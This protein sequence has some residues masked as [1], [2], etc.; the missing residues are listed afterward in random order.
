MQQ[1]INNIVTCKDITVLRVKNRFDTGNRDYLI[2][3]VFKECKLICE[4]QV[5]LK[6]SL[7][8]KSS[9]QQKFNH[10]LYTLCRSRFGPLSEAALIMDY[11]VEVGQYFKNM[12][13]RLPRNS[14]LSEFKPI[15]ENNM[16]YIDGYDIMPSDFTFLCN[17]CLKIS[18]DRLFSTWKE[19][20][21]DSYLCGKCVYSKLNSEEKAIFALGP[22]IGKFYHG[23]GIEDENKEKSEYIAVV[24][25]DSLCKIEYYSTREPN[26]PMD[27]V[28]SFLT[29]VLKDPYYVCFG[30]LNKFFA[31]KSYQ[32]KKFFR[33]KKELLILTLR[34]E[35]PQPKKGPWK[36][37]IKDLGV[38]E[39][40][41][42]KVK[43]PYIDDIE[44][45]E[46]SFY[47]TFSSSLVNKP[48]IFETVRC[49]VDLESRTGLILDF[50]RD[51]LRFQ[52]ARDRY[53]NNSNV[54]SNKRWMFD[55]NYENQNFDD[56]LLEGLREDNVVEIMKVSGNNFT[57]IN[58]FRSR[59]LERLFINHNK[60]ESLAA[61]GNYPALLE[62]SL[63][64]NG[65]EV[66]DFTVLALPKLEIL[67]LSNNRIHTL[68]WKQP[69]KK[70]GCPELKTL[71]L[72][73]FSI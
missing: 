57:R 6:E 48:Q 38:D 26:K 37:M 43:Y 71:S 11:Q 47:W 61:D 14:K 49:A 45:Q 8:G 35:E 60:I 16:I 27:L 59:S 1:V 34:I 22:E 69:N 29:P 10:F 58:L 15:V 12:T 18:S 50:E 25:S 44:E 41:D 68:I 64:G 17:R 55:W 32:T 21:K 9:C 72:S 7:D 31:S 2:N 13:K 63:I 54:K 20:E 46:F 36:K 28:Q 70:V 30:E 42:N 23:I 73:T 52:D 51:Y 56:A 3:F 39:F 40:S 33:L 4:V 65:L 66:I 24:M 53:L 67:N 5:G 19:K 62:L